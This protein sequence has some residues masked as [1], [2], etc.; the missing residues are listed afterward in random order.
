MSPTTATSPSASGLRQH[1]PT[2]DFYCTRSW[3]TFRTEIY[4][5]DRGSR[6]LRTNK[7]GANAAGLADPSQAVGKTDFDFF[8]EEHARTAYED[9]QQILRTGQPLV[10]KEEKETS[11]EGRVHWLSTT[12]MPFCDSDGTIIGT[13][14]VSRD[15]TELKRVEEDIRRAK[16]DWERTFDSVPDL[17][18]ILDEHHQVLRANRAMARRLGTTPQECVGLPC[19]QVVHGTDA[20]PPFCPHAQTL[21]DLRV[22][23]EEVH[24][25]RL[26]GDFLVTTTP[27]M[28][29]QGKFR[30]AVHV[31]RDVTEHKRAEDA[32]RASERR[33]RIFV[34]H[35]T[36]AFFLHD[37]TSRVLDVNRQACESLGCTREELTGMH[38][39]DFDVDLTPATIEEIARKHEAGEPVAF[40]TR[41]CRKDGTVFPVEVRSQAFWEGG[42]RFAVSLARDITDQKRAEEAMGERARLASL[43][44]DVG[45]A[46]TGADTLPGILQPCAEALVRHLG[47]AFGRIW[48]LNEAENVLELRAS[49]GMYTRIDGTFG[50]VPVVGRFKIGLIVQQRRPYLTN[51]VLNDP[52]TTDPEWARREGM[53]ASAGHPLIVQDRVVGVMVLFARSCSRRRPSRRSLA[54]L[55]RLPWASSASGKRRRCARVSG[56]SGRSWTMQA[57]PSSCTMKKTASWT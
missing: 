50:R 3:I 49:A 43:A 13:F 32:L 38:P 55:T 25:N 9:E 46:L 56:G 57:T 8:A 10:G 40:Q 5:K 34:D 2:N 7:S 51:D 11:R 30:G 4:F 45:V 36:D 31:A 52:L 54:W 1:W 21:T 42:R 44:A 27:L 48:T 19:Y 29:E 28:D 22:H 41:H 12:K 23:T 26:G 35:A 6:F 37:D 24:E 15:I 14:G 18:A 53:V 17:I 33:F 47:A 16:E 39:F 20:P